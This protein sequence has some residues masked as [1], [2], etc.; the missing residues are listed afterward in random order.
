MKLFLSLIILFS[1]VACQK[2]KTNNDYRAKYTGDFNFTV[3]S[4]YSGPN[5]NGVDTN[6]YYSGIIRNYQESDN[7]Q[8]FY[9]DDNAIDPD[10]K[11]VVEISVDLMLASAISENGILIEKSDIYFNQS[12]EYVGLNQIEITRFVNSPSTF[13]EVTYTIIGNRK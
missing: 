10:T 12:G 9:L 13:D 7:Q 8:N 6:Y 5:G 1:L 11:I 4:E 3:I 2:D